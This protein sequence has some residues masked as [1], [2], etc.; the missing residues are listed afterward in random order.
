ME[1]S[2]LTFADV[3]RIHVD[4]IERYGGQVGIRDLGL[5]QS[6]LAMPRASFGQEWLHRD[7]YE[8]AAAYA[9]H[10]SQN[11]PFVDGNKRTGLVCALAFL[12]IND[13]S[14]ADVEGRLYDAMMDVA[15]G[16]LDKLGLARVFRALS[17][18]R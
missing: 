6:A 2:F 17:L 10:L 9:F 8:M 1:P 15:S 13:V 7:L 11:H 5:L 4:Q 3:I 14:I 16:A 18:E 12:E